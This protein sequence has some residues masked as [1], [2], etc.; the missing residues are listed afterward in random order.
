[1]DEGDRL[2]LEKSLNQKQQQKIADLIGS[3]LKARSN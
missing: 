3:Y 2:S 1:M